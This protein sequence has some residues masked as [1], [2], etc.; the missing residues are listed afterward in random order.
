MLR[1][2]RRMW[3]VNWAEQ[4][5]YRANLLMYLLF[6][7]VSPIVYL[8]VWTTVA[9]GQGTVQGLTANDFSTYYL[10][11]LIVDNLTTQITIHLLAY[12]IQD[13][14][15]AGELL[16]P[17]HPILTN[18]LMN[19]LAFKV[20]MLMVLIPVWIGLCLLF[21]PDF[22]SISLQSLLLA[23]P[24]I[25][26][27]FTI[28]F[29]FGATITCVAFWTTRVYALN[30]FYDALFILFGGLFVPL[31]LLP[32]LVQQIAQYLP[33]QLRI[34]FPIE[35]I[36]GN[37]PSDVIARDFGLQIV[38]CVTGLALFQVVWSKGV[39]RFSAV[40]A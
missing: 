40:G 35:L 30:E 4:W 22:S 15:L 25:I 17:I 20:L 2:Y 28:S 12:K 27:G 16:K 37:L 11:L 23:I 19:N 36:L 14:T 9:N 34:Y 24:A 8:S 26:L 21:Q 7:L 38:W 33:F 1:I 18:T 32:P 13:G 3:Q 31:Q 10:T 39:K 5:Q 6:W 29:L